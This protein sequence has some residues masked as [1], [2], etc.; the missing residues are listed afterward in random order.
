MAPGIIKKQWLNISEIHQ[1]L[2]A[3][4]RL[5]EKR[6]TQNATNKN[7]KGI[8]VLLALIKLL[9]TVSGSTL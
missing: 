9:F 4:H 1:I 2:T 5:D 7:K 3:D 6:K 8:T